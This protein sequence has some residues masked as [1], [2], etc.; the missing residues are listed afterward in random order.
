MSVL[1]RIGTRK[2]ILRE[3]M[4]LCADPEIEDR[5]NEATESWITTTGGPPISDSDPELTVAKTIGA[6]FGARIL[7]HVEPHAGRSREIY[8]NRR[9]MGFTYTR[10]LVIR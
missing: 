4:W 10:Q 6:R 2:A 9:Q 5:L 7:V 1:V 8:F 3:G